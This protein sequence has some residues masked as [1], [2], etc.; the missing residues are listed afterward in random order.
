[1]LL[2]RPGA[3]TA[4]ACGMA[5]PFG[6][7]AKLPGVRLVPARHVKVQCDEAPIQ[8]DGDSWGVGSFEVRPSPRPLDVLM[9]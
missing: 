3:L 2:D 9:H 4:L 8:A 5:L 7:M 1:M 6:K